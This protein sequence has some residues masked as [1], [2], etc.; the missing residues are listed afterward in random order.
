M[1]SMKNDNI[2]ASWNKIGPS[3]PAN[4]RMLSAILERKRSVKRKDKINILSGAKNALIPAA[5]CLALLVAVSVIAGT[6]VNRIDPKSGAGSNDAGYEVDIDGT[7]PYEIPDGMDPITASLAVFPEGET[8]INVADAKLNS[9]SEEEAYSVEGLGQHLP[10]V[11]PDGY[12]FRH[13]GLYKT[14]MKSG[15][16]YYLLRVSY[17][18][19]DDASVD[20]LEDTPDTLDYS[21]SLLNFKPK[22]EVAVYSSEALP[23]DLTGKGFLYVVFG[24]MYVG[25]DFG[26]LT[27]DEIM[28][29]LGSIS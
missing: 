29:V 3:D 8:L 25:F 9:L 7:V 14:T 16:A 1:I 5:A 11:I 18:F 15:A 13:A 26:D 17:S 19:G 6:N 22:T 2:I 27:N 28:S 23:N 4:E 24:D 12:R 20:S 21:I 10:T